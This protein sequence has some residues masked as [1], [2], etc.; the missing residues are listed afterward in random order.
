MCVCVVR[1]FP[2]VHE[3]LACKCVL[4]LGMYARSCVAAAAAGWV[5]IGSDAMRGRGG[6]EQRVMKACAYGAKTCLFDLMPV[7]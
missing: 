2:H 4:L 3:F 1:T 5:D 7:R 6:A